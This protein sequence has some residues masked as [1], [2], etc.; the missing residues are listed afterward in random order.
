[1][2]RRFTLA[3]VMIVM[4]SAACHSDRNSSDKTT[5]QQ[6]MNVHC[7]HLLYDD[8]S[9]D[10]RWSGTG[11]RLETMF[12]LKKNTDSER[13]YVT[14]GCGKKYSTELEKLD[15]KQTGWKAFKAVSGGLVMYRNRH[16]LRRVLFIPA[17]DYRKPDGSAYFIHCHN[18]PDVEWA[19]CQ[20]HFKAGARMHVNYTFNTRFYGKK[21]EDML[22]HWYDI[23]QMVRRAM[24]QDVEEKSKS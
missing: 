17:N 24:N 1:M 22:S 21:D 7:G 11:S 19:H 20:V 10:I 12:R 18:D 15:P 16:D 4:T 2:T 5:F 6:T 13:V 23:D 3:L 9:A 8:P 14:L